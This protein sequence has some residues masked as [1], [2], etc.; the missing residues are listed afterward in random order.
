MT[1]YFFISDTHFGHQ[2]ACQF[3]RSDGITKMRP[4][5]TSEEMDETIIDRWNKVVKPNDRVYVLG[6]VAMKRKDIQTIGRCSGR[7]VLIRGNHDIFNM[8]DYTPYFDDIRG[9]HVMPTRDAILSHIPL[10]PDSVTR[11][12]TN[13]HGHLHDNII[14]D[15]RYFNVCVEHTGYAPISYEEIKDSGK[16]F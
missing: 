7:K 11:F 15:P 10:H 2:A 14:E 3:L 9:V 6:D 1:N 5:E 8:A 13:I 16:S 12:K 4:F